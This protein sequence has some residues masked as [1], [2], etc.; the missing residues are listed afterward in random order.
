[1]TAIAAGYTPVMHVHTAQ[2]AV[3][4]AELIRKIDP[5]TGQTVEEKP[6]FLKTGDAALVRFEPVRP[7]CLEV[8]TEFPALGRFAIRDMG[9]TIAAG[10]VKEITKKVEAPKKVTA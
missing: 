9:T 6:A 1:P 5:R 4:F 7:V 10:V 2:V 3:R 8:Y